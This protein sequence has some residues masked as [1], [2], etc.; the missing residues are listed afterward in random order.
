M[1]PPRDQVDSQKSMAF[2][3]T[4]N[5]IAGD[6]LLKSRLLFV[7]N[8][9]GIVTGGFL[10]PCVKHRLLLPWRSYRHTE[11]GLADAVFP[12]ETVD[13]PQCCG[14]FGGD[15]NSAG[16]A[17]QPVAERWCK[18]LFLRRTVCAGIVEIVED[19]VDEGVRCLPVVA[20]YHQPHRLAHQEYLLV[21]EQD[22]QLCRRLQK[23]GRFCPG[24]RTILTK[25][26]SNLIIT[27]I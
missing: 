24:L 19:A 22:V 27:L 12:N 10:V 23:F 8:G 4:E 2:V 11:V 5:T 15:D 9:D 17:V 20:V 18:T 14:S 7:Q 3:G 26:V 1:R 21:L 6:D 13:L 16:V 25:Q